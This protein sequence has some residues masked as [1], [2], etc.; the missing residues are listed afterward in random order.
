MSTSEPSLGLDGLEL[1]AM[2][3]RGA[4]RL[5]AD[6]DEQ[7]GGARRTELVSEMISQLRLHAAVEE[8]IFYPAIRAEVIDGD[9]L[10]YRGIQDH[11]CVKE[12]LARLERLDLNDHEAELILLQLKSDVRDHIEEEEGVVFAAVRAEMD[13]ARLAEMGRAV[14]RAKED[15][16]S[17]PHASARS[18]EA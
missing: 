5:L 3:H 17:H 4:E 6:I 10:A 2:G 12:A 9:V 18:W 11:Q 15:G 16:F 13:M 7:P 1:L 14:A 8:A